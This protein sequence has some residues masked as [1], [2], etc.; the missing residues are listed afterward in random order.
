[1][2]E[3]KRG[4]P[5]EDAEEGEAGQDLEKYAK[6]GRIAK[7]LLAMAR[8][9]AKVG[10]S[11]LSLAEELETQAAKLG[12]KPAFPAN[13]SLN[14][15]AAH[16]T[17]AIG[18]KLAIGERNVLKVDVGV[19]VDGFIAD[20]AITLDFSGQNG[21]LVEASERALQDALSVMKAGA[22][23]RKVGEE[24]KKTI[25]SFGFKPV[26]NLCGHSLAQ[27]GLHAGEEIPNVPRG[28]YTLREGDV[29]AVEPFATPGR[30]EVVEGAV[31]EI[32]SLEE[33]RPV[34]MPNSRKLLEKIAEFEFLPFPKR[35]LA[36]TLPQPSLDLAIADLKRQGLLRAYPIL[37]DAGR[38]LVS[39]AETTVVVEKDSARPFV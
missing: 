34:R 36:Q 39:Q 25:N 8:K 5:E 24:I 2:A 11:L 22:N 26:E 19:Q 10:T 13:L 30:G 12:G 17:P 16:R 27:Y 7:E 32:F 29:F 23:V 21:K 1:M 15:E 35:W 9:K 20:C 14:E 38:G 28:D 31:C 33:E 6:A 37:L 3:S 18:D 4:D